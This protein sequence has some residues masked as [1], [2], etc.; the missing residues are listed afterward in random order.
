MAA[1]DDDDGSGEEELWGEGI[2]LLVAPSAENGWNTCEETPP[3][4]SRVFPRRQCFAACM[5]RNHQEMGVA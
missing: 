5:M 1:G 2:V 4:L 3:P